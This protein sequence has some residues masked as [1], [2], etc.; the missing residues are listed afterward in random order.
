MLPVQ[1]KNSRE[2]GDAKQQL[3]A[4]RAF[5]NAGYFLP[6]VVELKKIISEEITNLLDIGCGEGYFTH[7]F[8]EHC[9]D[10]HIYGVDIAKEGVRLA[11][12]GSSNKEHYV[13]ASSHALPIAN[14]SMDIITRIYAPSKDEELSRILKPGGKLIIVTPGERHLLG[15]REQIY[16]VINP[17]PKPVT[18]SGFTELEQ[19][20]VSFALHVPAGEAT[21]ALLKMTPFSW[22]LREELINPLVERGLSDQAEFQIGVYE[23]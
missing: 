15:L 21:R 16:K 4:R 13:V 6:L 8:H 23:R 9:S 19:R 12:K 10:A 11:A 14:E 22:K 7:L 5:L 17:H 2:P 3:I 20:S 1:Y 18:P